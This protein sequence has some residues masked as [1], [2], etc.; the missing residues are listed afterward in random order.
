MSTNGPGDRYLFPGRNIPATKENM[1]LDATLLNT[2]HYYARIKS[3]VEKSKERSS[4][5]VHHDEVTTVLRAF[6][7]P[8]TTVA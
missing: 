1:V 5:P 7:S 3:N 6:G 2:Q 4:T 8:S